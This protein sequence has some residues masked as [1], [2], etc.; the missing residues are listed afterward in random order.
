MPPDSNIPSFFQIICSLIRGLQ[1][2]REGQC[3]AMRTPGGLRGRAG[4]GKECGLGSPGCLGLPPSCHF[5]DA[6]SWANSYWALGLSFLFC[7]VGASVPTQ[8]VVAKVNALVPVKCLEQGL[9]MDLE[10]RAWWLRQSRKAAWPAA[11]S[12]GLPCVLCPTQPQ[13]SD[14]EEMRMRA[15]DRQQHETPRV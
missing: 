7:K 15:S 12:S 9:L 4:G 2:A 1:R 8:G 3:S 13:I 5:V 11:L 10:L 14:M 6:R